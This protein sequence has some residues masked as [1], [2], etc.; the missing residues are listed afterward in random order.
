MSK[1]ET[2]QT[3]GVDELTRLT[4]NIGIPSPIVASAAEQYRVVDLNH[5]RCDVNTHCDMSV[6]TKRDKKGLKQNPGIRIRTDAE[7]IAEII[8]MP[9]KRRW[10][11]AIGRAVSLIGSIYESA[12]EEAG[13]VT[14]TLFEDLRD[15]DRRERAIQRVDT[16]YQS[17][18]S[19][20]KEPVAV[21]DSQVSGRI[22]P[23]PAES[24][25]V[26]GS[27]A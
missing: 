19:G 2:G 26:S 17:R 20:I 10:E 5:L 1:Q 4:D 16:L 13:L 8:G 21:M 3:V 6:R 23:F 25:I 7:Q 11:R 15:P 22:I 14:N 24:V 18:T 12:P 9:M 27:K